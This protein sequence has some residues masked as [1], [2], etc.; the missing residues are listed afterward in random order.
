MINYKTTDIILAATLKMNGYVLSGIE[1]V[2][3]KGLFVFEDVE[4]TILVDFDLGKICVE[5]VEFNNTIKHLT[6][7]VRRL[8]DTRG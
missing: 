6:T 1:R 7:S 2:G 4:E 8:I 5:P 3:N